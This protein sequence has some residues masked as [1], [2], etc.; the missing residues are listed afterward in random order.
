ME[1]ICFLDSQNQPI[2]A[3]GPFREKAQ[4]SR[5]AA[6]LERISAIEDRKPRGP[7]TRRAWAIFD[8]LQ[9]QSRQALIAECEKQ[10][11]KR[12]TA[13]TQYQLWK[14]ELAASAPG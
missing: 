3:I 12:G 2:Y 13:S 7:I 10:G 8:L 11:I 9:G 4:A 1:I 5:A 6:G 14:K